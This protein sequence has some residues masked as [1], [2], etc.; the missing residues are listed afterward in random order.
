MAAKIP[1]GIGPVFLTGNTCERFK[2]R[3]DVEL[4]AQKP[5]GFVNCK[6]IL[7]HIQVNGVISDWHCTK[8]WVE[9]CPDEEILVV[10]DDENVYGQNFF[11]CY[12][13]EVKEQELAKYASASAASPDG[14][15]VGEDGVAVQEEEEEVPRELL[16][17]RPWASQGSEAAIDALVV[18]QRRPPI[19][20]RISRPRE[21]YGRPYRFHDDSTPVEEFR[22]YRDKH[23]D[24][25]RRETDS[26]CQASGLAAD[27][28]VQ[29]RWFRKVNSSQ[30]YES[31]TLQD[32]NISEA[33]VLGLG[34]GG[35]ERLS[36]CVR[37]LEAAIAQNSTVDVS[38][39]DFGALLDEDIS[40]GSGVSAGL[41]EFQSFTDII[42]S[43]NKCVSAIDWHPAGNG[44]VAVACTD[45]ATFE[46]RVQADGNV[47]VSY[48]LVWS[49]EDPIHPK[50]VLEAPGD[51]FTF[52]FNPHNPDI[53]AAGC[54]NGLVLWW[55]LSKATQDDSKKTAGGDEV[56]GTQIVRPTRIS[57]IES[58][59]RR[60]VAD[61]KWIGA[62]SEI[63]PKGGRRI[64]KD[65]KECNQLVTIA[66]DGAMLFWDMRVLKE[67]KAGDFSWNPL[68][69][70]QMGAIDGVG[71]LSATV[72]LIH[73]TFVKEAGTATKFVCGTDDGDVVFGDWTLKQS[74]AVARDDDAEEGA[75]KKGGSGV[76]QTSSPA[77]TAACVSLQRS[78]ALNDFILTVGDWTFCIFKTGIK[79]P[80]FVSPYSQSRLTAGRWSPTR[81]SV[82]LIAKADGSM[83]FWDLLERSHEASI[84]VNVSSAA[85]G[86]CS[87][88]FAVQGKSVKGNQQ[89]VSAGDAS[90]TL[91]VLEVPANM[92]RKITNEK[93][94]FL[95]FLER[96]ERRVTYIADRLVFRS[97]ELVVE[98]A[99][100]EEAVAK[101]EAARQLAEVEQARKA[102]EDAVATTE[103]VEKVEDKVVVD[104]EIVKINEDYN[105]LAK[106]L[107]KKLGLPALQAVVAADDDKKKGN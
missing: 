62:D 60:P 63:G 103:K 91:H 99:A 48:I 77:H 68:F 54:I 6:E 57:Q 26:D 21:S 58:S 37:L 65:D 96:E 12:T 88:E 40:L 105:S 5:Y 50:L 59:H 33:E 75:E 53:V 16:P 46:E 51:C 42:Y 101:E 85:G 14:A 102:A 106:E 13:T 93:G 74:A 24:L 61:L 39:N 69:K 4:S 92:R 97:K 84:S 10:I 52:R 1:K 79:T 107:R 20:I 36:D 30:Q 3:P 31:L 87:V 45:R 86:I 19:V 89:L 29:T 72:L 35:G 47:P 81:P 43:K 82:I 76:I 73:D 67:E 32:L 83:E 18:Q 25:Q 28:A 15:A 41:K 100:M 8:A 2:I 22:P 94:L 27:A 90:G 38:T 56:S 71:D 66:S 23:Y 49:F 44:V 64:A 7:Q 9:Q 34:G 78:P 104:P 55:D 98:K 17:P 95:A 80:L 70:V 11:V